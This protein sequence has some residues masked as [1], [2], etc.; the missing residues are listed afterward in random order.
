MYR[1]INCNNYVAKE[2]YGK[3]EISNRIYRDHRNK[4][5]MEQNTTKGHLIHETVYT[6]LL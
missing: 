2:E 5:I 1:F 3:L 6:Q 4:I